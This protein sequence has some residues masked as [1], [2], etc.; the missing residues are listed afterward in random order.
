MNGHDEP[1]G[2]LIDD[3]SE[4]TASVVLAAPGSTG[5]GSTSTAS[6]T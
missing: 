6:T 1:V 4:V 5:H 3:G 2:L